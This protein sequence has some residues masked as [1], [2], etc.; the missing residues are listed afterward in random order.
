M[1]SPEALPS[2]IL[3]IFLLSGH[4]MDFDTL[5]EEITEIFFTMTKEA[6]DDN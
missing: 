6:D 5:L 4:M 2:Y 1:V 3:L